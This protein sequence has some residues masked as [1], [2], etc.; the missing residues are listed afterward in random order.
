MKPLQMVFVFYAI[1]LF[2]TLCTIGVESSAP[3]VDF[4][5]ASVMPNSQIPPKNFINYSVWIPSPSEMQKFM[6]EGD[7][8]KVTQ[9][10]MA[11]LAEK[12]QNRLKKNSRS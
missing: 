3:V 10:E 4:L 5:N 11:V 1:I 9:I 7:I 12:K 6:M 2:F 8:P